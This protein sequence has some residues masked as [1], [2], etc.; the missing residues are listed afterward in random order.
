MLLDCVNVE[1][2]MVKTGKSLCAVQNM[3]EKVLSVREQE[4]K[5]E[6]LIYLRGYMLGIH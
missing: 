3:K 5:Q 1:G 4:K 6:V 2:E